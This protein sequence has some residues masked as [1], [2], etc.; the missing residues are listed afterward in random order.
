[1]P[2]STKKV[3]SAG[4]YGA[5]YGSLARKKVAAVERVQRARHPCPRCGHE[6]VRRTDTGIWSCRKC[7]YTYAG[8]AYTPQT[9]SGQGAR[10][11]LRGITDKL[12]RSDDVFV[13][14][15]PEPV[16][17]VTSDA[18]AAAAEAEVHGESVAEDEPDQE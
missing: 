11:A 7:D 10:K 5:R 13:S 2:G 12:S 14:P 15:T 9:G 4:R 6:A 17:E 8:G 3:G 18:A 1:M 16:E